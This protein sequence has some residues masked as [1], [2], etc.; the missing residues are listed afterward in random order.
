[1]KEAESQVLVEVDGNFRKVTEARALLRVI[2]LAQQASE[3]KVRTAMRRYSQQAT[4]LKDVLEAQATLADAL[5]QY[6]R[7]L[8]SYW[9]AKADLD[10]AVGDD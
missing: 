6:Q 10:K 8:M 2:E 7:T 1:M 5:D 9:T 4:L 3:E